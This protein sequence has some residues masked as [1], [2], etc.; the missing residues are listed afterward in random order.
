MNELKDLSQIPEP[1]KEPA[2]PELDRRARLRPYRE[3][4]ERVVGGTIK[5]T[6]VDAVAARVVAPAAWWAQAPQPEP[7][8]MKK[9]E[10]IG[11]EERSRIRTKRGLT[12]DGHVEELL[13]R[14]DVEALANAHQE[15]EVR[16]RLENMEVVQARA[17]DIHDSLE[18]LF[19]RIGPLF[20]EVNDGLGKELICLRE[21]RFGVD[22]ETRLLMNQLK[23]VRQFFLDEN[24]DREV[25]RL[26]EFVDLC[27]RLKALKESGFLDTI[28]DTI[29]RL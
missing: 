24:H 17:R 7:K 4:G 23:E 3:R 16:K 19:G 28:A 27:E 14:D 10:N 1:P 18:Y 25:D 11:M 29:L 22:T 9:P 2:Q 6:P 13:N 15:K 20:A 26:R 8:F 21:K 5:W 12:E